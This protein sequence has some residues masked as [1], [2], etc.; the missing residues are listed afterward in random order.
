MDLV[1]TDDSRK[2]T[3]LPSNYVIFL[4]FYISQLYIMNILIKNRYIHIY[5]IYNISYD[6]VQISK[7]MNH[8]HFH[9]Y[10]V[11]QQMHLNNHE[12]NEYNKEI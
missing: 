12:L 3:L 5:F 1:Y 6:W 4:H 10:D 2:P 7:C 8:F 9:D 11:N